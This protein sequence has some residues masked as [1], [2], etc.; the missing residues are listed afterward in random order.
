MVRGVT[1][2][3]V[4]SRRAG[5]F[6]VVGAVGLVTADRRSRP[7]GDSDDDQPSLTALLFHELFEVEVDG[8]TRA[9]TLV[10]ALITKAT[11][12]D[13]R[14]YQEIFIRI[15]GNAKSREAET[16]DTAEY[17]EVDALTAQKILDVF[18]DYREA[19]PGH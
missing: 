2:D 5:E 16:V 18:D 13:I 11:D 12:G 4:K 15:D 14:A 7:A 10:E 9:Q 8:K 1:R 3:R 6:A 17:P 19:R